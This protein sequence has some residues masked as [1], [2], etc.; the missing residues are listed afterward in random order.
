MQF[1]REVA[2]SSFIL[3]QSSTGKLSESRRRSALPLLGRSR[4][5]AIRNPSHLYGSSTGSSAPSS[6]TT[7]FPTTF[8]LQAIG[9]ISR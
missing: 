9:A 8:P 6:S 1:W 4:R 5:D 7:V 3:S 2:I